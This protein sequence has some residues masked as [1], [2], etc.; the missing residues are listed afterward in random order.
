MLLHRRRG[1]DLWR[2]S[3]LHQQTLEYKKKCFM[4]LKYTF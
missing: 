3:R 1:G 4:Q 2:S